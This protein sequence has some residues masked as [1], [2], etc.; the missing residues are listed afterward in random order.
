MYPVST[1][2]RTFYHSS[3]P[4]FSNFLGTVKNLPNDRL[5]VLLLSL[6]WDKG[7]AAIMVATPEGGA[8][9]LFNEFIYH[10]EWV[11]RKRNGTDSGGLFTRQQGEG[12]GKLP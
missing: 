3:C 10:D 4:L 6:G 1:P 11:L 9:A 8:A 2:I 5:C 12:P 7:F